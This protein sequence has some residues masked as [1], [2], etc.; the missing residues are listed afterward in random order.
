[1]EHIPS[2][3]LQQGQQAE[4]ERI[5]EGIPPDTPVGLQA[6]GKPNRSGTG[7]GDDVCRRKALPTEPKGW[8]PR[9]L[10]EVKPSFMPGQWFR[11]RWEAGGCYDELAFQ[12]QFWSRRGGRVG[13][14]TQV[15]EQHRKVF[16]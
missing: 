2:L 4:D 8:G 14:K 5:T 3:V 10:G 13:L 12:I 16:P 6:G 1:M 9:N 7:A 11:I 15:P